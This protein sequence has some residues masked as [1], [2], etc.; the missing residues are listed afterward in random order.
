[1]L[2][3]RRCRKSS[4]SGRFR[5]RLAPMAGVSGE[6]D[7]SDEALAREPRAWRADV[8]QGL[9]WSTTAIIA[10]VTWFVIA[11]RSYGT[12]G[13]A[14]F[15]GCGA[16]V[17]TAAFGRRFPYALRASALLATVTFGSLYALLRGGYA[18]NAF[19][20]LGFVVVTATLLVGVR[21]GIGFVLLFTLVLVV[22]PALHRTGAVARV[23]GWPALV[24]SANAV[25]SARIALNFLVLSLSSV[26]AISYLLRRSERL[27]Q[28]RTQSLERLAAEEREKER[29]RNDLLLREAAF[30]KAAELEILGRLSGS[31]A[32]DYNNALVVIFAA[33]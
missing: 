1:M 24:D 28:E 21:A 7:Q 33:L 18:P 19:I 17:L 29:I 13:N 12:E 14:F 3:S 5:D 4:S 10:S 30:H 16:M 23:A 9:L 22:V 6:A 11:Q 2:I 20:A 32:H 27:L 25:N 31:M 8:L 15:L 26:L